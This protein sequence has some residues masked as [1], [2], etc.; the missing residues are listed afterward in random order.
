MNPKEAFRSIR[1]V[2]GSPVRRITEWEERFFAENSRFL[3]E[4]T[5]AMYIE[6]MVRREITIFEMLCES[7]EVMPQ[8]KRNQFPEEVRRDHTDF[9][10]GKVREIAAACENLHKGS[11]LSPGR[12][13]G[14][15]RGNRI[16]G[17][18]A[19]LLYW[20]EQLEQPDLPISVIFMGRRRVTQLQEQLDKLLRE[21]SSS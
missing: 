17:L 2:L 20:K 19:G 8:W 6:S 15:E 18:E 9:I 7:N 14:G 10:D 21:E 13:P 1:S 5:R 3:R 11:T 12:D 4:R 16:L